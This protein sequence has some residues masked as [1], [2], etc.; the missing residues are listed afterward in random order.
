M[1][2]NRPNANGSAVFRDKRCASGIEGLDDILNGGLPS[3]CFYLIQGD[4]GSGKTTLAL[5]FLLEGVR[6][7]ESVF[8]VT[9]SET[10]E[11]L[12]KVTRSHGWSLEK[13]PLMELSAIES[14][15]RPEAQTTVFHP[16]E[17]ELKKLAQV[18]LEEARKAQPA[19]VV[20]DS[21]SEFRLIAE[22]PLRY[23]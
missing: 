3:D 23:R 22:T 21:L 9:L 17:M 11:E 10:R 4:P 5:Q 14:L 15:L 20:F 16:A 18:I 13:I 19:R 1:K 6:R 12:L 2:K 7:G 8:Y